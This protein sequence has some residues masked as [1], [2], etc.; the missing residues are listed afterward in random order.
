MIRSRREA[1]AYLVRGDRLARN[2]VLNLTGYCAPMVVAV[3][4]IP[5]LVRGLGT[6][7]FGVLTLAWV[8]IGYLSLFDLGLGRALTKLV[9]E[10]L[11]E[12]D[13]E[14]VPRLVWP[15]LILMALLGATVAAGAIL[16]LPWGV[17]EVLNIPEAL[18]GETL[19]AFTLLVI[20]LPLV[21]P[22]IGMRG[23][24]DAYQRFGLTNTVRIAL[25]V[26][27][28]SAPLAVLPFSRSLVPVVAV[29]MVGRVAACLAHFAL[30]FRVVPALKYRRPVR[31]DHLLPLL[32][33]GGW[34]TVTNVL[35]PVMINLDRFWIGAWLS[36]T[37]VAYYATPN[38]V[39]TKLWF[40]PWALIGVLFPAFSTSAAADPDHTRRIYNSGSK[41]VFLVMF[42]VTLI[43]ATFAHEGLGFWLDET[44]A[45]ASGPV[46]ELFCFGVLL[47]SLGQIPCA[48]I[49]G[50]GRPD[51]T[52]KLAVAELIPYLIALYFLTRY[53][54]IVG[55]AAA[56]AGRLLLDTLIMTLMARHLIGADRL[57]EVR[58]M[59]V[60]GLAIG[61][62]AAGIAMDGLTVK[63]VFLAVT[64]MGFATW[65]W[66]ALLDSDERR[67]ARS[68]LRRVRGGG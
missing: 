31:R 54:G 44:F 9:A 22:S 23:V 21:I 48:L 19:G 65:A 14:R 57:Y 12:G 38:E 30:G 4:A 16:L 32:R 68:A 52:A 15:A 3:F 28:F 56:W 41:Y 49:Q 24:L 40:Y 67:M 27:T 53:G 26:Y 47:Y 45:K 2:V 62:M 58:R 11:G 7:R 64:L 20:F 63:V 51:L 59:A 1:P 6:D 37:A 60:L 29:L 10:A 5:V 50:V 34:M 36:V 43:I 17:T 35:N 18:Q 55:V 66:R 42:P 25:G 39:V 33:F 61:L 46:L 8:L 13:E